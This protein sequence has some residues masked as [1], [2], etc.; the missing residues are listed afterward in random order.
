MPRF[1]S[2]RHSVSTALQL[3]G[4]DGRRHVAEEA[5]TCQSHVVATHARFPRQLHTLEHAH[6]GHKLILHGATC[7]Y[8]WPSPLPPLPPSLSHPLGHQHGRKGEKTTPPLPRHSHPHTSPMG[9]CKLKHT[10]A[11]K[12]ANQR[13]AFAPRGSRAAV[14]TLER[15]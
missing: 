11:R 4:E 7:L 6:T 2:W 9:V 10:R 13:V 5:V 3:T 12:M 1:G 8:E 15:R 14:L